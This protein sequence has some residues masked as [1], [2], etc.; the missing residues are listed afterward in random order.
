MIAAS[1]RDAG[2]P[3]LR[4]A[5]TGLRLRTIPGRGRLTVA[6]DSDLP[7]RGPRGR[8]EVLY[9]STGYGASACQCRRASAGDLQ[10]AC[11]RCFLWQAAS[12]QWRNQE[13]LSR[14]GKRVKVPLTIPTQGRSFEV[15][16]R[17]RVGVTAHL[18]ATLGRPPGDPPAEQPPAT[19]TAA[20]TQAQLRVDMDFR[21]TRCLVRESI[22][23]QTGEHQFAEA[24]RPEHASKGPA[25]CGGLT[26]PVGY[27]VLRQLR[28]QSV[29]VVRGALVPMDLAQPDST[30][31]G[32][33]ELSEPDVS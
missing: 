17:S 2:S 28:D 4:K 31:L 16:S 23:R 33:E 22:A 32:S 1:A 8:S 18:V 24:R 5:V 30:K 9:G 27:S 6:R 26:Q 21:V 25:L 20:P 11:S 15:P 3:P 10:S 29:L 14:A 7:S 19:V 12:G 13:V